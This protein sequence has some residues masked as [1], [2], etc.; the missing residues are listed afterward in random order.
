M[1]CDNHRAAIADDAFGQDTGSSHYALQIS[2]ASPVSAPPPPTHR[3]DRLRCSCA[4]LM[5][6]RFLHRAWAGDARRSK[7]SLSH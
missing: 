7:R 4:G 2:A 5:S 6:A 1:P 3:A